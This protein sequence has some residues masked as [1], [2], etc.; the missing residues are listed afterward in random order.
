[1][2]CLC[3]ESILSFQDVTEKFRS[4]VGHVLV[5]TAKNV[6]F[7]ICLC[8]QSCWLTIWILSVTMYCS[9]IR[10]IPIMWPFS[11]MASALNTSGVC[12]LDNYF[13]LHW[14][15]NSGT[16]YINW[17]WKASCP[18]DFPLLRNYLH[19]SLSCFIPTVRQKVMERKQERM[20]GQSGTVL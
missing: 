17:N 12:C 6:R 18:K 1:M 4:A 10:Q 5:W 13:F 16:R 7:C 8:R 19:W 9:L 2:L 20:L 3:L 15:I 14:E 11:K